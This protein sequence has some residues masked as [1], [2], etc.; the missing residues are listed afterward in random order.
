VKFIPIAIFAAVFPLAAADS[1]DLILARMDTAAKSFQSVTTN[2][3]Q[4]EYTAVIKDTSP[5]ESGVL[6][7]KRV[8]GLVSAIVV[9]TDPEPRTLAI[10]GKEAKIYRPAAKVVEIYDI[11]SHGGTINQ[12]LLLAF[13]SSG[14]ELRKNYDVN[15]AGTEKIDSVNTTRL[16]LTPKGAETKKMI[17]KV[18]LWIP[19]GQANAIREKV[20][21]PSGNYYL[22]SY[23]NIDLKTPVSDS[24]F[25][26]KLPKDV[27]QVRPQH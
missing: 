12:F 11:G 19:D 1:L 27:Q 5:L 7:I 21:E 20:T 14:A 25:D 18:E 13:G 2:L 23:S 9:F 15:L 3:K 4:S 26:L 10:K 16:E 24:I 22:A 6:R 8:K 17:T